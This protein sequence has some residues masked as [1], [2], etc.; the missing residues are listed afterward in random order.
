MSCIWEIIGIFIKIQDV[1]Y[2]KIH[3]LN[4]FEKKIWIEI[5]DATYPKFNIFFSPPG[6]AD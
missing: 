2:P 4:D 3:H 6:P 5:Q 1:S